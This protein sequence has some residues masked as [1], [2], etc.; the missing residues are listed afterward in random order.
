MAWETPVESRWRWPGKEVV[1]ADRRKA[2]IG[3]LSRGGPDGARH[4]VTFGLQGAWA[5]WTLGQGPA[6][7]GCARRSQCVAGDPE[8]GFPLQAQAWD[9]VPLSVTSSLVCECQGR[10]K[11][12]QR[13]EGPAFLVLRTRGTWYPQLSSLMV[14]KQVPEGS[15]GREKGGCL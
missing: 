7:A 3:I 6:W 13:R 2:G 10:D 1:A 9:V 12:R 4:S 8:R 14:Q 5:T 11:D 15:L